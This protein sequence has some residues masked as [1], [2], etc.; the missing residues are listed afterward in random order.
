MSTENELG[1]FFLKFRALKKPI[2]QILWKWAAYL[3]NTVQRV[4]V[5]ITLAVFSNELG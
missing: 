4:E 5:P 3:V 1:V 2:S